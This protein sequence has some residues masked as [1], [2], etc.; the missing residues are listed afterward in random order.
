M[1]KVDLSIN[2]KLENI[3]HQLIGNGS[4]LDQLDWLCIIL[5][6]TFLFKNVFFFINNILLSFIGGKLIMDI[7]N[8]LFSH[9][10]KLPLS[11]FDK[12]KTGEIS[13]IMMNDVSNMRTTI[14]TSVQSL[15][16]EPISIIFLLV[17]CFSNCIHQ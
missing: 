5:V 3:V 13:S 12:N 17:M 14:F 8:Q 1:Q 16:N 11:F 15:I 4:Q 9:I 6:I 10:Q 2:D 7:R